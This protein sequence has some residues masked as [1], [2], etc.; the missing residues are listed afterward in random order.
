MVQHAGQSC[1]APQVQLALAMCTG[2]TTGYQEIKLFDSFSVCLSV[3]HLTDKTDVHT[4]SMQPNS[5]AVH[6][7]FVSVD[8]RCASA[9]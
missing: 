3:P 8:C 6:L 2:E 1:Y 9:S 4:L 7:T 5:K